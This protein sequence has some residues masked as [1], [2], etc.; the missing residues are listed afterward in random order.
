MSK[1]FRKKTCAV[2]L[3][4]VAVLLLLYLTHREWFDLLL[5]R[6]VVERHAFAARTLYLLLLS[7]LGF[8]FL[9]STPFAVSGVLLFSPGE[10]YALNLIGILTS[11]TL[12]YYFARYLGLDA[13]FEARF[14]DSTKKVHAALQR[15]EFPII[16]G[17]SFFPVV[18]TDVIIYVSSTLNIPYWKCLLGV[19]LGEGALNACYIFSIDMLIF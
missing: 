1:P 13:A 15:K 18:P 10:A 7:L 4:G 14:P 19:L 3:C 2:W 6:D 8:T 17:W 9:P 11:S 5:L 16:V 12:I